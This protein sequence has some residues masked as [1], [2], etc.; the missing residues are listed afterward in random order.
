ME[1][2]TLANGC[3]WCTE[4][5]FKRVKGVQ[6]VISGYAGGE[7]ENP[8]YYQLHSGE[9]GHAEALQIEFN[10]K[11]V[12]FDQLLDVFFATHDPTTLN[13]QGNDIGPQYR[14]AIFYHSP[15]QKNIAENKI[16]QI[17]DEEK[18]DDPI[19][20]AIEPFTKFYPA[21]EY[22]QNFYESGN[23]PDYCR[24]IID[25]KIQKLLTQFNDKVKEEYK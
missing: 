11:V 17:T 24:Y 9:T 3:F 14:S 20:T 19:V 7:A 4:A 12:S 18:Y 10:P 21:E 5:V 2:A 16:K 23:R 22:H 13:R 8:N 25:P 1:K 15:E 6:S